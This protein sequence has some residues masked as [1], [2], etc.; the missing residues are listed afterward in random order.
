MTNAYIVDLDF[1][2]NLTNLESLN[3]ERNKITN[4][5]G[6][7]NLTKLNYLNLRNNPININ[8]NENKEIYEELIK[9]GTYIDIDKYDESQI[10]IIPD[11]TLS[12]IIPCQK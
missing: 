1:L 6:L 2:A 11:G 9:N 12:G 3:L 5:L 7:S 10:I 8:S 4:I